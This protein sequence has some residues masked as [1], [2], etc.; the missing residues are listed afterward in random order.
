MVDA[1]QPVFAEARVQYPI[2]LGAIVDFDQHIQ[3]PV[4]REPIQRFQTL[5]AER[6]RAKQH[7]VG[8]ERARLDNLQLVHQKILADHWKCAGAGRMPEKGLVTLET[9]LAEPQT[10]RAA[11]RESMGPYV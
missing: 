2:E 6:G 7:A 10:G 8:A 9:L 11:G 5:G 4:S 1:E 3:L